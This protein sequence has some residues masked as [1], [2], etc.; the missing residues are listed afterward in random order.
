MPEVMTEAAEPHLYPIES[1]ARAEL[2][3]FGERE[4]PS[5]GETGQTSQVGISAAVPAVEP[6][7]PIET[8]SERPSPTRRG[9]WQWVRPSKS[10]HER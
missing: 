2:A 6:E 3:D 4:I 10:E 5:P 8:V 7:R 9:W 1:A